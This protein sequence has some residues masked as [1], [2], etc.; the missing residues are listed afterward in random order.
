MN[1]LGNQCIWEAKLLSMKFYSWLL[2]IYLKEVLLFYGGIPRW[3]NLMATME[4][5]ELP[6]TEAV[7]SYNI[8]TTDSKI[9]FVGFAIC[10]KS[11]S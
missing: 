1:G 5:R 2:H 3:Q 9:V 7:G 10:S 6:Q 11:N 8:S 4:A